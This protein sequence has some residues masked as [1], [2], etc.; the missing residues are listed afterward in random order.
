[1]V[2]GLGKLT[3]INQ[4]AG[5]IKASGL[6]GLTVN[7]AGKTLIN[8]GLLEGTGHGG[9]TLQG[10]TIDQSAGGT[11]EAI[12]RVS[13][14]TA[15]IVG[16]NLTGSGV[17]K[18]VDAGSVL[19]G[20]SSHP[21][22]LSGKVYVLDNT[23]LT[24]QGQ[25]NMAGG[26]LKL[27]S[28]GNAADLIVAAA[29]ATIAGGAITLTDKAGNLIEGTLTGGAAVSTLTTSATLTGAGTLG[30]N[31]S[32]INSG[33]I[34]AAGANA[35]IVTTGNTGVAGSNVIVNTGTLEA[36]NKKLALTGGLELTNV[37]IA[38][39]GGTILASGKATHVDLTG[40]TIQGG[41]LSTK[42]G[43]AIQVLGGGDLLD[44]TASALTNLGSVNI[45]LNSTLQI[46]GA[47][48]NGGTIGL[49]ASPSGFSHIDLIG[50]TTLS[51]GGQIVLTDNTGNYVYGTATLT[52]FDNT[53]AGAGQI[54]NG[55]LTLVNQSAG[56]IEA[57]GANALILATGG[58]TITNAGILQA[59]GAGG[60]RI[61]SNI[62]DAGGLIGAVG[63]G[64][65]VYLNGVTVAG[66]TLNTLNGGTIEVVGGATLDGSVWSLTNEGAVDVGPNDTLGVKGAIDNYGTINL[67]ASPS[68]F[69]H[70]NIAA[71]TTL[72]KAGQVNLSDNTGNYIYG[73]ATLTNLDNTI[74]G[75]GQIGNGSLTLVNKAAGTIDASA[76][77]NALILNTGGN[78]IT[79]AGLIE[80]TGSGGLVIDSNLANTGT[81]KAIGTSSLTIGG[82]AIVDDTKGGVIAPISNLTLSGGEILG[83]ALTISAG[84]VM[85]VL[86][87][88]STLATT[89]T[90]NQGTVNI[91][92]N[93]TLQ[94]K[95][96]IVNT[97]AINL[98]ASPSGFSHI[99]VI[100]NATLSGGGQVA[101]TDN[102]G[103]YVYGVATLTNLDNTIAGAGQ[104]GNGNLILVNQAAGVID[105]TGANALILA[106]GGNRIT[107]AGVIEA[108]GAGELQLE[109]SVA[110][111]G[112]T[113][114]ANGAGA[115]VVLN[116]ITVAGGIL[117]TLNGGSIEVAGGATLDGSASSLTNLGTVDV[118]LN[119]A[120]GVK[121]AVVNAGT[122]FL[123]ASPS[124]FSHLDVIADTTLSGAGEISLSGNAGNYIYGAATLTNFNNTVF[125]AGQL[126]N[127]NLTLINQATGIIDANGTT[128]LILNTG[129]NTITNAG[130]IEA[131][132]AGGMTIDSAVANSGT[133]EVL[134]SIMT[135]D[136]A[137]SGKGVAIIASGTLAFASGFTENVTF[138][139][140][141]GVLDLAQSQT[142]TGS[143]TGFSKT[144]GTQL[145]LGDIAFV[146][147]AQATFKGNAT[148]GT[149]TVTDG[150]HT[151]SLKLVGDYR[152]STFVAASDGA[153]GV[154]IHDPSP[155]FAAT[156]PVAAVA[157][158]APPTVDR[159]VAAMAGFAPVTGGTLH[160]G[161]DWHGG[162]KPMLL[163]PRMRAA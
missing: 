20:L 159:F 157:I 152:T 147:S 73:A 75:A 154:L 30:T 24:V 10:T 9:L 58:N 1:G 19:D 130:L 74:F 156:T 56:I 40:V 26:L 118:G 96:A 150:T 51:G 138:T 2:L 143:I 6:T 123:Q 155:P 59:F 133:L 162:A 29:G 18:T 104:I 72:S 115:A 93:S 81:I 47:I 44:G 49:Q 42:S 87:G 78:T 8:A 4:A 13:L 23:S 139:G 37:T 109:S 5:V 108:T 16:G 161:V 132:G 120:L 38:N 136:G 135:V 3:L 146:G 76:A 113:L 32:L 17:I 57:T 92:L 36:T 64:A 148:S 102:T 126:G 48:V 80:A 91:G 55:N 117:N 122:I 14:H 89:T 66:G 39:A 145:D 31:L 100:G 128:A 98:T 28:T 65:S 97:G 41:T 82:S 86:G 112:G 77:V 111:A 79:N 88:S 15:D 153:G 119:N 107:N 163:T 129:A 94:V 27:A 34:D 67:Q 52:N 151:A 149:L 21:I 101:L 121:G 53:I 84:G 12:S 95:S 110:N 69:S 158:A 35:L 60:L 116:G 25:I 127:G 63:A 43:G 70:L 114:K 68:G 90:T 125:G 22:T 124:G 46:K 144:G 142:Y 99:D 134:G 61:D 85:T 131:V 140:G 11:I 45:G 137:V 103:N 71:D 105:A 106:T 54:G 160:A 62:A 50:N 141:T 7:T 33:V 83:G